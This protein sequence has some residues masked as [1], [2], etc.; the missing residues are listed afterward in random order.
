MIGAAPDG[1]IPRFLVPGAPRQAYLTFGW[2]LAPPVTGARCVE[3]MY[4][5]C[6][7]DATA[8]SGACVGLVIAGVALDT[9]R[10]NRILRERAGSL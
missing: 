9:P 10:C 4:L 7:T 2:A 1:K 5:A 6:P 8:R 3:I